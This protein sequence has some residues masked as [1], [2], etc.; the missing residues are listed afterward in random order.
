MK[1][2]GQ[3]LSC[4]VFFSSSVFLLRPDEVTTTSNLL[5]VHSFNENAYVTSF[6]TLS[7]VSFVFIRVIKSFVLSDLTHSQKW[8]PHSEIDFSVV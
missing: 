5:F 8:L 3:D 4:Y 1:I 7:G 2:L 6:V